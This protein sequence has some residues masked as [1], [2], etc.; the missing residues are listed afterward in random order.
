MTTEIT[1]EPAT[2][3]A[4]D[5]ASASPKRRFGIGPR[6]FLA[7]GATALMTVIASGVASFVFG[8]LG[9][10]LSQVTG[11]GVPAITSALQ[12]AAESSAI[13]ALAPELG[14]AEDEQARAQSA[15]RLHQRLERLN[16]LIAAVAATGEA[17]DEIARIQHARDGIRSD[18]DAL[19]A[20]VKQRLDL[21]AKRATLSRGVTALHQKFVATVVPMVD[22]TN[23]D[24]VRAGSAANSQADKAFAGL[25]SG[26]VAVLRAALE[27]RA[28]GHQISGLIAE[29]TQAKTTAELDGLEKEFDKAKA[30]AD[31]ILGKLPDA[32]MA[33]RL[34]AVVG[35][36]TMLATGDDGVFQM[37]RK[38]L[39][40]DNLKPDELQSLIRKLA[41][42]P[43]VAAAAH[44]RFEASLAP[45]IDEANGKMQSVAEDAMANSKQAIDG[46]MNGGVDGMRRL[47][48]VEAEGN[49]M[50][51][52][53]IAAAN[54]TDVSDIQPMQ[55]RFAT[56]VGHMQDNM[57]ALSVD[58]KTKALPPL[59][60]AMIA[61]GK[62]EQGAFALRRAELDSMAAAKRLLTESRRQATTLQDEVGKLV[63]SKEAQ[64][65]GLSD[66]ANGA[67]ASGKRILLLIA[68]GSLLVAGLIAWLYAGRNLTRRLRRLAESMRE[69]AAGNLDAEVPIGGSDEIATM[70][71]AMQVFK[72]NARERRRLRD[73]QTELERKAA[74]ERRAAEA[75]KREAERKAQEAQREAEARAAEEKR[76]G[77]LKLADE[78]EASVMGIVDSLAKASA[79]LH[80]TAKTLTATADATSKTTTAVAS[81]SEQASSN[82]QTVASA[83][84][85]MA[86]SIGEIGRQVGESTK[87]A[88]RAVDEAAKTN[89]TV[90]GLAE[91]AQRIDDVVNLINDI[92]GQ[93]NLLA[94]N[95]TI[96]AARAGEA[97]KG[98][99]VVASEV[100]ALANQ[101]AKATEEIANQIGAMQNA[102]TGAVSAIRTIGDTIS[103]IN[104][105]AA[106]IASAIEEQGAATREIARNVQQAAAGTTEV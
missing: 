52:L 31:A 18:L 87:I 16:K 42:E 19:D 29:A 85:E 56:A 13:A 32:V 60:E 8:G 77:M 89:A 72:E 21:A 47:L 105:I 26:G 74:E 70:A 106:G 73:E 22:D 94:L 81:A 86:G 50:A 62:G 55:E 15:E 1:Q 20:A 40:P 67:V 34:R 53:L 7:F 2:P 75:A 45:L 24:L 93:T 39:N 104:E 101:T 103:Q 82:V 54:A 14:G 97:G 100:K 3:T 17:K 46:L 58:D 37:Q 44:Q 30:S 27:I 4:D 41:Q 90:Q 12:L 68:L 49:L 36:L 64:I 102:T 33:T 10:A 11:K 83:A 71:D 84:E 69:L 76:A 88:G 5:G 80:G 92:A 95:A 63:A 6:L 25:L 79:E 48:E 65:A 96:E 57:M 78:L 91:A 35:N 43:I 9:G 51:G 59:N 66:Q 99:A 61:F 23:F 28:T 98:F 38:M